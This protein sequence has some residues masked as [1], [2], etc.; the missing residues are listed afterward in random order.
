MILQDTEMRHRNVLNRSLN[1]LDT[2]SFLI[3][4]KNTTALE[5]RACNVDF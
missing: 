1:G 3:F 2:I 4:Y 5:P